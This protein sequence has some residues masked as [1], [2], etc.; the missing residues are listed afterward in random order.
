MNQ[1]YTKL[2]KNTVP[3]TKSQILEQEVFLIE[4]RIQALIDIIENDD[5]YIYILKRGILSNTLSQLFK[6]DEMIKIPTR[7]DSSKSI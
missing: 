2:M 1:T 3:F 4:K 7:R 5:D 6:I